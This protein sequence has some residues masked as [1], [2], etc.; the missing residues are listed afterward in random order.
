VDLPSVSRLAGRPDSGD[1]DDDP[2]EAHIAYADVDYEALRSHPKLQQ[3]YRGAGPGAPPSALQILLDAITG[4]FGDLVA[5]PSSSV[6]DPFV[7]T[8]PPPDGG[9]D[10]DDERARKHWS[11][12]ARVNVLLRNFVKRFLRGFK[13]PKF[14]DAVGPVVVEHNYAVFFHLLSRLLDREWNRLRIRR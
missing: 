12:Q 5:P 4:A 14:H 11:A 13:S 7:I 8:D 2:D 3:Y 6:A 10:G 1:G 9:E